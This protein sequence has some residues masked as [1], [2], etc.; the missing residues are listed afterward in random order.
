MLAYEDY[1]LECQRVGGIVKRR[2]VKECL[3]KYSLDVVILQEKKKIKIVPLLIRSLVGGKLSE[4]SDIP[5]IG[6]AGGMVMIWNPAMVCKVEELKGEYS[7][8]VQFVEICSRYD[9]MFMGVYGPC[10]SYSHHPIM[11]RLDRFLVSSDWED[12]YPSFIQECLPKLTSDHWPII[13]NTSSKNYGP[14]PFCFE[15]VWTL[16]PSFLDLVKGWWVDHEPGGWEGFRFLKKLQ[17]V[18]KKIY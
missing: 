8:S 18:K 15:N 14:S 12:L 1:L 10:F 9:C 7:I 3:Q 17:F 13:I 16:H 11:C 2:Y 5:S 4:W 6:V